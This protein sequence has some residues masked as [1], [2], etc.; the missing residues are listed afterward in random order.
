MLGLVILQSWGS[1]SGGGRM[2]ERCWHILGGGREE[3]LLRMRI[4]FGKEL[5]GEEAGVSRW[6]ANP[7]FG[8]VV[9]GIIPEEERRK[10]G[11]G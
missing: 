1:R 4:M 5:R 2:W 11:F 7:E 6:G 3:P 10:G 9:G 8:R